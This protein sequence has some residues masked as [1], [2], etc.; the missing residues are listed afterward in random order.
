MASI[1]SIGFVGLGMMGAPMAANLVRG[2]FA[3]HAYDLRREAVDALVAEGGKA[4]TGLPAVARCDAAIVMVNTDAQAREVVDALLGAG[5]TPPFA[6]LS[7]STILPRTARELGA[8]SAAAGVGFLDAPVSGG[9]VVAR[10]GALAIMVG[11]E[12]ALFERARPVLEAMGRVVRL[13]GDVG[14]GLTVKLVN[15]MIAIQT[16]PVVAE[17]LRVGVEQGM[18]LATLVDVIRASSGNTWITENWD[19]ARAFLQL[20]VADPAQLESLVATGRKDLELARA[21]CAEA[22]LA[23]PL[24]ERAIEALDEQSVRTLRANLEALL[25]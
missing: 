1:H 2:G 15:N 19:Q 24:L 10:L 3:V 8:R 13:V 16:L 4:A 11:G 18:D 9:V 23:A 25:R 21:F 12:R 17:S 5:P 6:I 14:A 22:G 7:M 20:M